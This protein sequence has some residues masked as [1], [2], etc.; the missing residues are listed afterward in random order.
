MKEALFWEK[1]EENIHCLLCPVNCTISNGK[2]GFCKIRK[3]IDGGLYA[4]NYGKITSIAIDPMEKKPLYRFYPGSRILSIGGYSCNMRCPFCQNY[5][6]S[7][8]KPDLMDLSPEDLLKLAKKYAP[9]GNIGV[10]YTYN[11]PFIN[12]EYLLDSS[13]LIKENGLKNVIVT[14]G[15]VNK[16]PLLKVLPFIDAMNI[17]LKGFTDEF[18]KKLSGNLNSIKSIIEI[19]AKMCHVEI[20]TLIIPGENDSKEE[21]KEL[22]SFIANINEDIPLHI[23][24]F[25]PNYKMLDKEKTPKGTLFELKKIAD[26]NLKYVYL[27]NI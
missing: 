18:Y 17:D 20:T 19:A 1:Q 26:E 9:S 16:E 15:Y 3:N 21:M 14:N 4:L 6:I 22:S 5:S 23:S 10:A 8:E 12:Y 2:Y 7:M 25:F 27:G 11:E 24:R 13:K